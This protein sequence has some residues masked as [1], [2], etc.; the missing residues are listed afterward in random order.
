MANPVREYYATQAP[1][2][3]GKPAWWAC[4]I[5]P[6]SKSAVRVSSSYGPIV[7]ASK[8]AAL[9]QAEFAYKNV[10]TAIDFG[11]ATN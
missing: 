6:G 2:V 8:A 10:K 11:R 3:N 1:K 4:Y 9:E 5:P 7:Y